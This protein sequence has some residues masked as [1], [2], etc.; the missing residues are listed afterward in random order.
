MFPY[1]LSCPTR[2]SISEEKKI[3]LE[4][5]LP[6]VDIWHTANTMHK[7][8]IGQVICYNTLFRLK[9][10]KMKKH[11]HTIFRASERNMKLLIMNAMSGR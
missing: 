7:P 8:I 4:T 6:N 3:K 9:R 5:N 2:C 10:N 11:F 1:A